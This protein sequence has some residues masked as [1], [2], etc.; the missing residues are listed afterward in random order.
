MVFHAQNRAQWPMLHKLDL[1]GVVR[2]QCSLSKSA[3]IFRRPIVSGLS[4]RS[5][6]DPQNGCLGP[7]ASV[8]EAASARSCCAYRRDLSYIRLRVQ[9]EPH[10]IV[11][12]LPRTPLF[13]GIAVV[14]RPR[15]R[16]MSVAQPRHADFSKSLA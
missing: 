3:S 13:R 12:A 15:E 6:G 10:E 11:S 7:P 9:F 1:I 4:G 8:S 14:S 2:S 16:N 5:A